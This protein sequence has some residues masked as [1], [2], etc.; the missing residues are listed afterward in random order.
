MAFPVASST[1]PQTIISVPVQTAVGSRRTPGAPAW[2]MA[3]HAS[4][5]GS[6]RAPASSPNPGEKRLRRRSSPSLSTRRHGPRARRRNGSARSGARI[7]GGGRASAPKSRDDECARGRDR[8][9]RTR[10]RE[11][12]RR[13]SK[14]R[15]LRL[16]CPRRQDVQRGAALRHSGRSPRGSSRPSRRSR[17]IRPGS[18]RD[19]AGGTPRRS[20]TAARRRSR[21]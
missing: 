7:R 21:S 5:R 11:R 18:S 2:D 6:Y 17:S 9:A 12:R 4:A 8:P 3:R 14:S 13:F 19:T 20:R 16:K 1:P 15:W 10:W